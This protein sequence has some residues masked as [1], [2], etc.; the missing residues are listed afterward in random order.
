LKNRALKEIL[1]LI[2]SDLLLSIEYL[3]KRI[4]NICHLMLKSGDLV[5]IMDLTEEELLGETLL[6]QQILTSNVPSADRYQKIVNLHA[7]ESLTLCNLKDNLDY[8]LLNWSFEMRCVLIEA[9]FL[10]YVA[11][12]Y[13]KFFLWDIH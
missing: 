12:T 6:L 9:H 8:C 5:N 4:L 1:P 11:E 13:H 10:N 2:R 3:Q 7:S